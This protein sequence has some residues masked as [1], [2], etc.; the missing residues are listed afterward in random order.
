MSAVV[1]VFKREF[2]AYF[3]TPIAFVFLVIFLF[4]MGIFTFYVGHFYDSGVADL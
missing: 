3:A 4:S 1:T 2:A